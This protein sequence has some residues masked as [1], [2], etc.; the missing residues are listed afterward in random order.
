MALG[1]RC[2]AFSR[3]GREKVPEGWMRPLTPASRT[4]SHAVARERAK[5]G[6]EH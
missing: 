6:R 2:F 1:L 3:R 4:L 5:T